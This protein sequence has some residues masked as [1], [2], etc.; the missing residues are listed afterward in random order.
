MWLGISTISTL[1]CFYVVSG[2]LLVNYE[3]ELS[4]YE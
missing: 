1:K 3:Y 2:N 4:T